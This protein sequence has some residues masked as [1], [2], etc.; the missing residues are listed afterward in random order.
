VKRDFSATPRDRFTSLERYLRNLL[1]RNRSF[2][3]PSHLGTLGEQVDLLADRAREGVNV[4]LL[5]AT[6]RAKMKENQSNYVHS[7]AVRL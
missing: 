1:L 3:K 7:R 2:G 6:D 5:E 4:S